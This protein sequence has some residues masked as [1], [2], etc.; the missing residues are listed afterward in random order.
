MHQRCNDSTNGT[1]LV[2]SSESKILLNMSADMM[3]RNICRV[4]VIISCNVFHARKCLGK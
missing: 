2:C 1:S 3:L 4:C